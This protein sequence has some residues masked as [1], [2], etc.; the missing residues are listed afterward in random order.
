MDPAALRVFEVKRY[1][2]RKV[3]MASLKVVTW[4][5][6]SRPAIRVSS[7]GCIRLKG[8]VRIYR[9]HQDV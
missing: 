5:Y 4:L 1:V 9:I 8:P 7:D 2:L 6:W 3:Y